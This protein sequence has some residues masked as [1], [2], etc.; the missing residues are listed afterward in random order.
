MCSIAL[1][2]EFQ[3]VLLSACI[4]ELFSQYVWELDITKFLL[5][6]LLLHKRNVSMQAGIK[7]Q[8]LSHP[9]AGCSHGSQLGTDRQ[10]WVFA[11]LLFRGIL[12]DG[13]V[14]LWQN[15][16]QCTVSWVSEHVPNKTGPTFLLCVTG[17]T[18]KKKQISA[19][20]KMFSKAVSF[21]Y[22]F[23]RIKLA[24]LPLAFMFCLDNIKRLLFQWTR[25]L[26]FQH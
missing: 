2:N 8:R 10:T 12:Q 19:E 21:N 23:Q 24:W 11:P 14:F 13:S 25:I 7:R 4:F 26:S 1:P 18:E 16:A 20:I 15:S 5:I 9:T 3:G 6:S 17:Y 22:I